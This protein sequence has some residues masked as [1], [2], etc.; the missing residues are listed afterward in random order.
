MPLPGTGASRR[1]PAHRAGPARRARTSAGSATLRRTRSPGDDLRTGGVRG[2]SGSLDARDRR[3]ARQ[4]NDR[5][6][7]GRAVCRGGRRPPFSGRTSPLRPAQGLG[8]QGAV[9]LRGRSGYEQLPD[10]RIW[11]SSPDPH[12]GG[13]TLIL[14]KE[15]RHVDVLADRAA[16]GQRRDLHAESR[17]LARHGAQE[18]PA[19]RGPD[20]GRVDRAR[21]RR[22][23]QT[24]GRH[25]HSGGGLRYAIQLH[26]S[27]HPGGIP[28]SRSRAEYRAARGGG[29]DHCVDRRRLLR[30]A[31]LFRAVA[32]ALCR[33]DRTGD[34]RGPR[35]SRHDRRPAADHQDRGS[36]RPLQRRRG[37]RLHPGLQDD[38]HARGCRG[39]WP[40]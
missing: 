30:G 22:Q 11:D 40:G 6:G 1:G 35:R 38:A 2:A 10:D 8:A 14:R 19:G 28:R 23:W 9:R 17:L 20:G 24:R 4:W 5:R 3:S 39:T 33:R 27:R 25:P 31:R 34:H 16:A 32:R 29:R 7:T 36:G 12:S 18:S 15:G 13:S 21:C 37:R 26:H